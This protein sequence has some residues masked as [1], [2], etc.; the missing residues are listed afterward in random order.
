MTEQ[1]FMNSLRELE[2]ALNGEPKT[3]EIINEISKMFGGEHEDIS[4]NSGTG[5]KQG[6]PE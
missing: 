6:N 1:E 5:R 3:P 2:R 4:S